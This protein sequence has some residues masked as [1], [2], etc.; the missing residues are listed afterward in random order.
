MALLVNRGH[1]GYPAQH[2]MEAR[3]SDSPGSGPYS[4]K[5]IKA[6]ALL[7]D[8]RLLLREWDDDADVAANLGRLHRENAFGKASRS[9]VEDI[10]SIFRQR[11]LQDGMILRG[12]VTLAKGGMP[13]GSL[14]R[15]L[16]FLTLKA[17]ALL[18]DVV[19]EVLAPLLSRGHQDVPI[20]EV[21]RWIEDQVAQGRTERPWGRETVQ[22]VAQGVMATLRDFGVLQGAVQKRL[23]PFSLPLPAFA[24]VAYL[25]YRATPSG[26]RLLHH[27]DWQPFFL[28]PTA[29]ERLFIE[30]HQE[31]LLE[32]YAAGRV[33][34]LSFPARTPEEYARVVLTQRAS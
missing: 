31:R 18:R 3:V 23:A 17:D 26:D 7:P 28:S 30:A 14:D 1:S 5:I 4:S 25:M 8:T 15:V 11:Y 10:L 24:F 29:V 33:V 12:L 16:Y 13:T 19:V 22:R 27:P 6:S 9:R 34:R 2:C 32:Y 20:G 21:R